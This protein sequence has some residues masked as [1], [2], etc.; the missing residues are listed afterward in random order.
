MTTRDWYAVT[1]KGEKVCGQI[2]GSFNELK[3]QGRKTRDLWVFI[4]DRRI[5]AHAEPGR[6]PDGHEFAVNKSIYDDGTLTSNYYKL[7]T[8][9]GRRRYILK[10]AKNGSTELTVE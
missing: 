4:G 3:S 6:V 1:C 2:I 5:H 7:V 9:Y 10:V 8:I